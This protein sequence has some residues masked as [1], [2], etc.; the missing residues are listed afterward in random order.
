MQSKTNAE[1]NHQRNK[2]K[3]DDKVEFVC[4][5]E[6]HEARQTEEH[7]KSKGISLEPILEKP[8]PTNTYPKIEPWIL[9]TKK[10]VLKRKKY[11]TPQNLSNLQKV[12]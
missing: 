4:T 1:G 3:V 12:S 2:K 5:V 7:D 6:S 10:R 11:Q 8:E 9:V